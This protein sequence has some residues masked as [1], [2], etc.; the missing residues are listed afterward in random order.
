I[1]IYKESGF[2]FLDKMDKSSEPVHQ[3]HTPETSRD[4]Q[5]EQP[6]KENHE[7][8]NGVLK[9]SQPGQ[10]GN[11]KF[12][13]MAVNTDDEMVNVLAHGDQPVAE[14]QKVSQGQKVSM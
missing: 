12:V 9:A 6:S 14:A 8:I 4:Q 10:K 1:S 13:K 2:V 3:Q 7:V 11:T 5:E